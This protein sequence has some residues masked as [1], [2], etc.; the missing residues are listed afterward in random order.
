MKIG[1][2]LP[3]GNLHLKKICM[4]FKNNVYIHIDQNSKNIQK[5]IPPATQFLNLEATSATNFLGILDILD[6]AF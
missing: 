3:G 4:I 2:L 1:P 5:K 6:L